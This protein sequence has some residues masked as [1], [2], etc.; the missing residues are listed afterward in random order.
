MTLGL[1]KFK[2]ILIAVLFYGSWITFA[3]LLDKYTKGGFT[4]LP[5]FVFSFIGLCIWLK[6]EFDRA[7]KQ[8][9]QMEARLINEINKKTY[10]ES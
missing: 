9:H 6:T 1:S 3:A 10:G 4:W 8:R 2:L 7:E 5:L